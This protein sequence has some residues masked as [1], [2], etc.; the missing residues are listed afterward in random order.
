[1]NKFKAGC[2]A[3]EFDFNIIINGEEY[4]PD[5]NTNT[6]TNSNTNYNIN[7]N[8]R[9]LDRDGSREGGSYEPYA[10]TRNKIF[11]LLQTRSVTLLILLLLLVLLLLLLLVL[12][13][14]ATEADHVGAALRSLVALER[15]KQSYEESF[16][17]YSTKKPSYDASTTRRLT[18]DHTK[19]YVESDERLRQTT[20]SALHPILEENR[21]DKNREGGSYEPYGFARTTN[22]I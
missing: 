4:S 18:S 21:I 16:T 1:M 15:M 7:S 17:Q 3:K 8:D 11:L 20:R 12:T 14:T 2:Y 13:V 19:G 22:E 9:D 10:F 5:G 6:N